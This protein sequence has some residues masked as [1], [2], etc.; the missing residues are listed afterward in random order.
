MKSNLNRKAEAN[1][2]E[3]GNTAL[4]PVQKLKW[5]QALAKTDPPL[6]RCDITVAITLANMSNANT[7]VCWPSLNTLAQFTNSDRRSVVRAISRLSCSGFIQVERNNGRSNLYRLTP[8]SDASVTPPVTPVSLTSDASVTPPGTPVSPKSTKQSIKESVN[9]SKQP[10]SDKHPAFWKT[11]VKRIQV[12]EC[13]R[14]ID[15][16]VDSGVELQAIVD[17]AD[18]WVKY[19]RQTNSQPMTPLRWLDAEGWRDEWQTKPV[20]KWRML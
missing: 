18:R 2:V 3:Q 6:T 9:Q 15:N 11:G 1:A 12:R 10:P 5:L 19:T 4:T 14:R 17:G 20:R 7:G 16:L 13:E 8:A